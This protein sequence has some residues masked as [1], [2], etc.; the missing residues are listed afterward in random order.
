MP[1]MGVV[2]LM[3]TRLMSAVID[4]VTSAGLFTVGLTTVTIA[5]ASPLPHVTIAGFPMILLVSMIVTLFTAFG[6]P[7]VFMLVPRIARALM[8]VTILMDGPLAMV[9]FMSAPVGL[10]RRMMLRSLTR[11]GARLTA[12]GGP[13]VARTADTVSV[14]PVP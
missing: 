12:A 4:V 1:M 2:R 11:L 13:M 6:L 8:T 10:T 14:R 9:A 5:V 3:P 7:L